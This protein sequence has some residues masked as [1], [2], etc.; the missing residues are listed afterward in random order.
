TDVVRSIQLLPGVGSVGE[1]S[2]GFNVRGG[3]I[4]QNL[5]LL[6][7]A[8]VYNSSHLFGFFS[9][10][11]PD[12]VK[13]VKLI[14]GGI[15]AEY[16][17]RLSSILD[18]RLNEGNQRKFNI[19]GGVG[20]IFSRLAIE[21]PII[22]DKLSFLVAARRSYI[23]VLSKPFLD[24]GLEDSQFYFYDLTAKTNLKVDENNTIFASGYFV[25]D[26]FDAV[27]VFDWGSQT[28]TT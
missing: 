21:G 16:G 3:G 5:V 20:A 28:F 22:E 15:P 9:V 2:T 26:V 17:G 18:V 14:K 11:N 1:G 25:R 4:D 10:F 6:D 23:D 19:D 7:E 8:P 13:D 24:D 12:A 27:F